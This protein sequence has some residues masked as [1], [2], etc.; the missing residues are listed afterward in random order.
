MAGVAALAG[1]IFATSANLARTTGGTR[2]EPR[3]LAQL[4]AQESDRVESLGERAAALTREIDQ[5]TAL[6]NVGGLVE[7]PLV[8]QM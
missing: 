7:D 2:R 1:L 8:S 4:V 5:L 6:A 3:N